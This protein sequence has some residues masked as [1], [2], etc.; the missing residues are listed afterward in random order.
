MGWIN[1]ASLGLVIG[2]VGQGVL[3][4]PM[5]GS[6]PF[7]PI[8]VWLMVPWLLVF[9][10]SFCQVAPCGP[11][12]F[13]Q[14]LIFSM[15]WYSLD[16]VACE[17]VWLFGPRDVSYATSAAIAHALCYGGAMVLILLIRAVRG[18]RRAAENLEAKT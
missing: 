14:I 17:L 4:R 5:L 15:A 8:F 7:W 6:L 12:R 9:G 3:L 11:R 10:V 13:A 18:A 2:A 16:T 1:L